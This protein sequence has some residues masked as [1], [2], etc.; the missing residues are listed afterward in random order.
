MIKGGSGRVFGEV[1]EVSPEVLGTL[2]ELE[3]HPDWYERAFIR[4][5]DGKRVEAYLLT[6]DQVLGAR[7]IS[8]GDWRKRAANT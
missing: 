2:D 5:E 7:V 4:L 8:T 6:A 1:Y 3:G